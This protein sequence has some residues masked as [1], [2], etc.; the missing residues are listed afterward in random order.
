MTMAN[1][2]AYRLAELINTNTTVKRFMIQAPDYKT[3]ALTLCYCSL[4]RPQGLYSQH[5]IFFVTRVFVSRRLFQ[6]SLMFVGK[7]RDYNKVEQLKGAS[8]W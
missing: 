6:S 8:L 3:V 7:A 2:P 4:H 1:T 5:F